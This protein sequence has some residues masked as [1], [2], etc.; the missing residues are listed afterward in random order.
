MPNKNII[1]TRN[2]KTGTIKV[3]K[4]SQMTFIAMLKKGWDKAVKITFDFN[5][6]NATLNFMA[7]IIGTK[8]EKFPFETISNHNVPKTNAHFSIRAVMFDQSEVNYKGNITIKPKANL[9]NAY[10]AHHTLMLSKNAKTHTVPSLEIQ[11]NDVKAGHAATIGNVDEDM[12]FYLESRGLDKKSAQNL[13]IK[14]FM[15]NDI[16]QIP[17]KKTQTILKKEIF[18]S[19]TN[20]LN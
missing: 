6:K 10:L 5:G 16:R 2:L 15:E 12:I 4:N 18:K 19:L 8:Q 1:I 14:S 17:D 9:A 11:A 7:F 13:L 20:Y 3:P